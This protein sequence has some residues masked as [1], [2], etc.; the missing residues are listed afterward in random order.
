MKQSTPSQHMMSDE[1]E[2]YPMD[3]QNSHFQRREP[4]YEAL[5]EK[6]KHAYNSMYGSAMGGPDE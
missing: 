2:V 6:Q 1:V 4:E 5:T 3:D